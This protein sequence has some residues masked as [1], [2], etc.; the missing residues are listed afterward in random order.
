MICEST[1]VG[2]L[3]NNERENFRQPLDLNTDLVKSKERQKGG[4]SWK[5]EKKGTGEVAGGPWCN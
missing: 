4:E 1:E 2:T 5:L 3:C